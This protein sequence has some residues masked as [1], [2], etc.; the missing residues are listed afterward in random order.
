M[1]GSRQSWLVEQKGF[2]VFGSVDKVIHIELILNN[3]VE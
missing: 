2:V 1:L 3:L